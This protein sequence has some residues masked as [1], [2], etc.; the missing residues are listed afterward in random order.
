MNTVVSMHGVPVEP[1][2]VLRRRAM[3]AGLA[4]DPLNDPRLRAW[5][6]RFA[7]DVCVD[8]VRH[9]SKS[10]V[11]PSVRS[12]SNVNFSPA[13]GESRKKATSSA[14]VRAGSTVVKGASASR[15]IMASSPPARRTPFTRTIT[16]SA[17]FLVSTR[18]K[19]AG[20]RLHQSGVV[21]S[22]S[23]LNT[24]GPLGDS[25]GAVPTHAVSGSLISC[26]PVHA[27]MSGN[28][29]GR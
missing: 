10:A 27:V 29:S 14:P 19:D 11:R 3:L 5:S 20:Q 4:A 26:L 23:D 13:S 22:H 8:Q 21:G 18:A 17:D 25:P 24:P 1:R 28:V 7:D 15:T 16:P 6:E 2:R 9:Y 12:R